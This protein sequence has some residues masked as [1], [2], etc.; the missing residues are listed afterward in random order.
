MLLLT[1]LVF[2]SFASCVKTDPP[3]PDAPQFAVITTSDVTAIGAATA[4]CSGNVTSDSVII[5]KGICFATHEKPAINDTKISVGPGMGSF[6]RVMTG[7]Q[8]NTTYYVRAYATSSAGTNY[9]NQ[10][11][12]ITNGAD[13]AATVYAGGNGYLYAADATT[14]ALK[15][16]A[17]IGGYASCPP[18]LV[19]GV[20]YIGSGANLGVTSNKLLAFDTLGNLKWSA[21]TD[22]DINNPPTVYNG[23]VYVTNFNGV[24]LYAFDAATGNRVWTFSF[25]TPVHY[26]TITINNNELY[27]PGSE[28]TYCL[29]A[30]TGKIKWEAPVPPTQQYTSPVCIVNNKAYV[31]SGSIVV[32]LDKNTGKQL[33]EKSYYNE[34]YKNGGGFIRYNKGLLYCGITDGLELAVE[35]IDTIDGSKVFSIIDASLYA[36]RFSLYQ[37]KLYFFTQY[38]A[39]TYDAYTGQPTAALLPNY[40]DIGTLVNGNF[41]NATSAD[42]FIPVSLSRYAPTNPNAVWRGNY[43]DG[44]LHVYEP[45]VVTQT[46]KAYLGLP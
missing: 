32:A 23:M 2:L 45:L 43:N 10:Q 41:Y 35:A 18:V 17:D 12:F 11:I 39:R 9:G 42:G 7:L 16:K 25:S 19:N 4:A 3:P 27:L 36:V 38:D 30:Q 24:A 28:Y 14:G 6:T 33:W 46:G 13:D 44:F 20:L 21:Q 26:N 8:P 15:W 34:I 1:L 37:D 5:D 22:N 29:N 40:H 31:L